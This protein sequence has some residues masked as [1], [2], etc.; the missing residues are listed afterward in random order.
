ML[1]SVSTKRPT[2][3][4]TEREA[5]LALFDSSDSSNSLSSVSN[6]E[7]NPIKFD[8]MGGFGTYRS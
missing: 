6:S 1:P 2:G 8:L 4:E 7:G 3:L 5:Q